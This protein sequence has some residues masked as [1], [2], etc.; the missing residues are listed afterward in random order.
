[1]NILL[2]FYFTVTTFLV[3]YSWLV[4]RPEL[5]ESKE[6]LKN[7]SSRLAQNYYDLNFIVGEIED[8]DILVRSDVYKLK[9]QIDAIWKGFGWEDEVFISSVKQGQT[10]WR[11]PIPQK[12][13]GQV[14]KRVTSNV[15]VLKTP[16][17]R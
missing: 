8:A 16:K 14:I 6:R 1:M 2:G 12:K 9:Q 3:L 15:R 7:L 4:L 11:I 5:K 17:N 13:E 10:E